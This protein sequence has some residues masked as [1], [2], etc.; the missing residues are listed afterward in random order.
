[1]NTEQY[2][3]MV[4]LVLARWKLFCRQEEDGATRLLSSLSWRTLAG[5]TVMRKL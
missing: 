4:P 2:T 3:K 1:M 5:T